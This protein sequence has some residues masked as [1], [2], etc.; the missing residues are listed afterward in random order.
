MVA[1]KGQEQ[2]LLQS[3][4]WRK[5]Q[6]EGETVKTRSM[7]FRYIRGDA[8]SLSFLG[9]EGGRL[10]EIKIEP[11]LG[12]E[13]MKEDVAIMRQDEI[14]V[15]VTEYGHVAIKAVKDYGAG[16]DGVVHIC[17]DQIDKLIEA[18]KY[19]KKLAEQEIGE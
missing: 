8:H 9:G 19:S 4:G 11:V 1:R 3:T 12:E 15:Y 2:L 13:R 14:Q 5:P 17:P 6:A 18:L 16:D 7:W 10:G